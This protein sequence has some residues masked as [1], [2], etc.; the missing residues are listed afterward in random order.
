MSAVPE[1]APTPADHLPKAEADLFELETSAGLVR[2]PKFSRLKFGVVRRLRKVDEDE[3]PFFLVEELAGEESL[4]VI[5]E[6][7]PDEVR[8]LFEK[9]QGD[10]GVDAG[11]SS[12]S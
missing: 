2:L 1:N 3:L 12:A 9:W 11:N 5:D 4:A 7:E 10:A 8:A 6:L